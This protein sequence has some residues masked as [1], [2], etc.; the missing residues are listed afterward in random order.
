[1]LQLIYGEMMGY[2]VQFG[3]IYALKLAQSGQTL[4]EK[5]AGYLA[6]YLLLHEGNELNIMLVNTLQK[7]LTSSNYHY[8]VVALVTLSNIMLPDVIPSV[9]SHVLAVLSH[10]HESVRKRALIVLKAFYLQQPELVEPYLSRLT[11]AL[12]DPEP[13]VMS[14]ALG[15]FVTVVKDHANDMKGLVPVLIKILQQVVDGKLPKGYSYHRTPAPWIQIR[16]LQIMA[17]LGQHDLRYVNIMLCHTWIA[18]KAD[19]V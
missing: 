10:S 12:Y 1:M 16:C 8:V 4:A 3:A 14:A 17:R 6:C 9:I 13:S 5:R 11:E 2:D 18:V 7:D 19:A 15:F